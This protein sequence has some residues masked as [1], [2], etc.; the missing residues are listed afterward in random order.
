ML[1]LPAE[2]LDFTSGDSR[3][4]MEPSAGL[5]PEQLYD[6]QWA[7]ALLNQVMERLEGEYTRSGSLSQFERLKGF[8]VGQHAGTTYTAV[9][10]ALGSTEAAVKMKAH[11]M[12]RRYRELLKQEIAQTVSCPDDV[13]DEIRALFATFGS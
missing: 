7:V 8:L 6:R 9:A 2:L 4:T 1:N 11:R 5:T 13:D 10:S 3:Y 12:R